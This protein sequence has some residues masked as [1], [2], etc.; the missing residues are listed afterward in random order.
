MTD[1]YFKDAH[2]AGCT[3]RVIPTRPDTPPPHVATFQPQP[4]AL[5]RHTVSITVECSADVGRVTIDR[6]EW[7][8]GDGGGTLWRADEKGSKD[9][10][11][12]GC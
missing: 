9:N 2:L 7:A 1:E 3:P 8:D 6:A 10:S 4:P 5:S 12:K 11:L